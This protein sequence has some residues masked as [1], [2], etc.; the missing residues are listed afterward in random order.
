MKN[1]HT[2]FRYNIVN[3]NENNYIK[4]EVGYILSFKKQTSNYAYILIKESVQKKSSI[5]KY[6]LDDIIIESNPFKIKLGSN[7]FTE[8]NVILNIKN[9]VIDIKGNIEIKNIDKINNDSFWQYKIFCLNAI[10]NGEVIVSGEKIK[11]RYANIHLD[12]VVQTDYMD[13]KIYAVSNNIH[14][15][16]DKY[17]KSAICVYIANG[18]F[19]RKIFSCIML[20][21]QKYLFTNKR[22]AFIESYKE[23]TRGKEKVTDI[24][25][26]QK[27]IKLNYRIK[28]N[29]I[30]VAMYSNKYKSKDKLIFK[31]KYTSPYVVFN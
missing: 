2:Y 6:D 21:D 16:K 31:G 18:I 5:I 30:I 3:K 9:D 10:A 11:F 1:K 28:K 14:D 17:A 7:T 19:K 12:G 4:I 23:Y 8:E 13:N 29:N 25:L 26:K 24:I 27:N 15:L 20:N 22:G